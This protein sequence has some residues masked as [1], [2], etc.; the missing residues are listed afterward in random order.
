MG[1][2]MGRK[3]VKFY[4]IDTHVER[5]GKSVRVNMA[6]PR[7]LQ[8]VLGKRLQEALGP[9][10]SDTKARQAARPH[11]T[12]FEKQI[13]RARRML[14]GSPDIDAIALEGL[15][16]EIPQEA[17][18][19]IAQDNEADW[20][21][22]AGERYRMIAS[23]KVQPLTLYRDDWL[24]SLKKDK[25]RQEFKSIF[26]GFRRFAVAQ[27]AN[28]L[29]AV[30]DKVV[31]AWRTELLQTNKATGT[32]NKKLSSMSA[33][34]RFCNQ[35]GVVQHNPFRGKMVETELTRE[36]RKYTFDEIERLFELADNNR[37]AEMA[38]ALLGMRQSA[39]WLLKAEHVIDIQGI[40]CLRIPKVKR[41]KKDRL[42]PIPTVML[43]LFAK[44]VETSQSRDGY[45]FC[46]PP[47]AA[48]KSR[49]SEPGRLYMRWLRVNNFGS[50]VDWHSF[51]RTCAWIL[52]IAGLP[53]NMGARVI[54]HSLGVTY[55]VYSGESDMNWMKPMMDSA[56]ARLPTK[57][58]AAISQTITT[59]DSPCPA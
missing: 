19:F 56:Y 6:V 4:Q 1:R 48:G 49:G 39:Q 36:R 38:V 44:L 30:T 15:K 2:K 37:R 20:G 11:I 34:F 9:I 7:P 24:A 8:K 14:A 25:T 21:I 3:S 53:E 57:V 41:E 10:E 18:E 50:E 12:K 17:I 43:P 32:V 42:I 40:K 45:L 51:R 31:M 35:T 33:Y 52:E 16:N 46:A 22:E 59:S 55:G 26:E 47:P 28:S 58:I 27:K 23:G 54:G 29:E 13:E 5:R